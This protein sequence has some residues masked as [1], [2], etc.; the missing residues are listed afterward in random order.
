VDRLLGL[1][2]VADEVLDA[3]L[4]LEL[5]RAAAGALVGQRDVEAA[6]EEGG[7]AQALLE[8]REVEVERL[9]DLVVGQE[10][11]RRAGLLGRLALAQVVLGLAPLVLLGK[12][13]ALAADLD[14][15]RLAQRIHHR[16]ADAVQTA[17]D[18]VATAVAELAAGVQD[19]EN[20]LDSR[21]L[22]LL[23]DPHGDARAVVDDRDRV[24]GME[25]DVDPRCAAGQRLVHGVVDHLIDEV[26]QAAHAGG[27]DVHAGPLANRLEP[28]ED[29]D[30]L[31][32]VAGRAA[33]LST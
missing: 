4:V 13:V 18:L 10:G 25:R 8:D 9:E 23:H 33:L 29:R 31:G 2:E 28:L 20:D 3:A 1:V 27:A 32:V 6:R 11:D 15:Q 26:V 17:G 19:R 22:L 16:D 24:I 5:D 14:L 12:D 30:V 7:L 21:A